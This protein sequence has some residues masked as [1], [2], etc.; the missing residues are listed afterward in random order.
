M[1]EPLPDV[2][3][4]DLPATV[5]DGTTVS[6]VMHR[7]VIGCDI[8]D[9]VGRVLEIMTAEDVDAVVVMDAGQAVGV[10]SQTDVV[11]AR[12]GRTRDDARALSAREVMTVGCV[13]VDAH[14][15][16]SEAV[17]LMT[18]RRVHRLV[19][20]DDEAPVGVLSMADVVAQLATE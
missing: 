15:L 13:T 7:G 14:A 1:S 10:V 19:V 5:E 11:L 12:Q 9:T 17:T 2:A 4:G 18:G 6:D 3:E 16:L 20:T 8:G